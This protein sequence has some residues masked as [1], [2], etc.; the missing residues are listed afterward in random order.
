MPKYSTGSGGGGGD[1]GS[2]ELCGTESSKLRQ[3]NV[4]GA[5][6]MVCPDCASHGENKSRERKRREQSRG[7]DESEPSRKKRAAQRTAKMYDAGTGDSKHWEQE[8]T[9]YERDRLPYLV[10]N[11]GDRVAEAREESELTTGDLA[12]EL[13]V[14]ERDLVAVEEGRATRAGVGGSVIRK[15]ED[16]LGIDLVDE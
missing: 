16:R 14:S 9:N 2:C 8:G 1:G 13:D 3:E 5:T 12:A 7:R 11:Y 10:R 6:L 4:A 15:L